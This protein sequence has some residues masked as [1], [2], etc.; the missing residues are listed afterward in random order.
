[1]NLKNTFSVAA[2][3]LLAGTMCFAESWSGRLIDAA[4]H[5]QAQGKAASCVPTSK[6]TAFGIETGDGK[7]VKLDS[8]GN[9]KATQIM[10]T[11]T[12]PDAEVTVNGS[13]SGDTVKVDSIVAQQ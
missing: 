8:A 11:T 9:M 5:E 7:V 1:M 10:K 2:L 12:K 3:V 13:L 4:C 6:T